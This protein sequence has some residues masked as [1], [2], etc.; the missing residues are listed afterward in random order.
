[1]NKKIYFAGDHHSIVLKSTL[2]N[3]IKK[4]SYHIDDLGPA[5]NNAVDYPDYADKICLALQEDIKNNHHDNY[6]VLICGS[7]IGMSMAANRY[8]HI[9]AALCHD[10]TSAILSRQH[11]NANILVLGA[12]LIGKTV[13]I[14]VL[15]HFINTKFEGGRHQNRIAKFS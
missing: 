10:V 8:K 5:N 3:M 14:D 11:N 2:I 12:N 1:M 9:R 13:A 4:T 15:H 6:G 7:G